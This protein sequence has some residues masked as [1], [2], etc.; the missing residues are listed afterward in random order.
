MQAKEA[1]YAASQKK[2]NHAAHQGGGTCSPQVLMAL[3]GLVAMFGPTAGS[4]SKGKTRQGVSAAVFLPATRTPTHAAHLRSGTHS[5][6]G[7]EALLSLAALFGSTT[8]E[9]FQGKTGQG[10]SAAIF[11]QP[12]DPS[13]K[14]RPL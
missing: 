7:S 14:K 1:S 12:R 8:E 11:Y 6:Q 9:N 3:F 4:K 13:T 2:L 5:P 10:V